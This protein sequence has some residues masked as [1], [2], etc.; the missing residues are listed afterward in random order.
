MKRRIWVNAVGVH[1]SGSRHWRNDVGGYRVVHKR[2]GQD[3]VRFLNQ[4]WPIVVADSGHEQVELPCSCSWG[5]KQKRDET[6]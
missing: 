6:V 5:E 2:G 4:L 1:A 3:F